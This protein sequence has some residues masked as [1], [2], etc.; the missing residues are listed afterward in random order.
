M[1]KFLADEN[2]DGRAFRMLKQQLPD[3]EIV[4]VQDVKLDAVKDELILE[5]AASNGYIVIT[6]DV[7]TM[8]RHANSRI[9]QG[10]AMPGLIV[11]RRT[12]PVGQIVRELEVLIS[13][14]QADEWEDRTW[15][16]PF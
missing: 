8:T 9:S 12:T 16:V 2:F 1:L 7:N 11:V 10:L 14:T 15:F 3:I 13:C 5:W 4:H 6:H